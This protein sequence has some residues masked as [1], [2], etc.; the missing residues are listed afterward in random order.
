MKKIRNILFIFLAIF[1]VSCGSIFTTVDTNTEDI[2]GSGVVQ[3][4]PLI[5]DLD[6]KSEKVEGTAVGSS[7]ATSKLRKEAV[8]DAVKKAKADVLIE[9]VYTITTNGSKST[10][11]VVGRPANY[12]NFRKMVLADTTVLIVANSEITD[13]EEVNTDATAADD[14]QPV[15]KKKKSVIVSV[16]KVIGVIFLTFIVIGLIATLISE[17]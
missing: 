5:T 13:V 17:L 12:K 4:P 2:K 15:E 3:L 7:T 8:A 9:P 10:V 14:A 6:I 1:T 11:T 16:L